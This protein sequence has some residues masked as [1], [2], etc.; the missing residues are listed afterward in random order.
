M[1]MG[2]YYGLVPKITQ[3]HIVLCIL[4]HFSME[5][6]TTYM[7]PMWR[8]IMKLGHNDFS[9]IMH[10]LLTFVGILTASCLSALGQTAPCNAEYNACLTQAN[11]IF[12]TCVNAIPYTGR[13]IGYCEAQVTALRTS[14][15]NSLTQ[16][17]SMFVYPAFHLLS[18]LYIPPGDQSSVAYSTTQADGTQTSVS[19]SFTT[20]TVNGFSFSIAGFS[21][22]TSFT[23]SKSSTSSS[24]DQE[25]TQN[26][27][28]TT[29]KATLD[30]IDHANDVLTIWTNPQ[31]TI[32]NFTNTLVGGTVTGQTLGNAQYDPTTASPVANAPDNAMSVVTVSVSQLQNPATIPAGA[33]VSQ[34]LNGAVVPGLLK[35]CANRIPENQ[36]TVQRAAQDGCG[37]QPSDFIP[38]VQT[39]PFFDP[40]VLTHT[41][42]P[43]VADV[44]AQDPDNA[45]FVPVLNTAH[46]PLLLTL[47]GPGTGSTSSQTETIVDTSNTS[48]TFSHTVTKQVGITFGFSANTPSAQQTPSAFKFNASNDTISWSQTKSV[49]NTSSHSHSQTV[50][51]GTNTPACFENIAV[52]EDTVFH[53]FA[54]QSTSNLQNPCP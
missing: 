1:N 43:G 54:F 21:L 5:Y 18:V 8:N 29:F 49:G 33:L 46:N 12:V 10:I 6:K 41:P 3:G 52:Y 25:T 24:T 37:C 35:F 53:T 40:A 9:G 39:D 50:T 17:T 16:C 44:N 2:Q 13:P 26:T 51:L 15:S 38:I 45:R 27:G 22:G 23:V 31:V 7:T 30:P 42:T 48:Q 14:C 19:S 4:E 20:S 36:C 11:Q 32:G 34:T 47:A 28:T